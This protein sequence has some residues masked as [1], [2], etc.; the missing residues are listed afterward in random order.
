MLAAVIENLTKEHL[1][2]ETLQGKNILI[3]P[4][5]VKHSSVP[6]DEFC[7]ITNDKFLIAALESLLKMNP[8][9]IVIGDAPIQ[10]TS[11]DKM[12]SPDFS[13]EVD[14]LSKEY[15]VPVSI[16]DFRRR[17]YSMKENSPWNEIKPMSEYV[18]F[19]L[20]KRSMLEPVTSPGKTRF[21]VTNYDPDRMQDAHAPGIHKYCIAKEFFDADMVILLPKVKTHQK[22]GIT[23]ALKNL[24]GING[25][26]DFL[27]H[28]RIG[29]TKRGGIVIQADRSCGIWLSLLLMRLIED[30]VRKVF[31]IG[32]KWRQHC[33]DYPCRGRN[34]R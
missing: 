12:L 15:N 7:L 4:N 5:W 9:K 34:I 23:G 6:E 27:P 24:V 32:R 13:R 28:H 3:K 29:G 17:K 1:N 11:W 21:R 33:G 10:L 30:R 18:I 2:S 8:A 31:G 25:D 26:K 14:R 22:T 19:D 16:I 20:G